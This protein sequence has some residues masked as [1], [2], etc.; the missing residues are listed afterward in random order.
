MTAAPTRMP[1]IY[2]GHGAPPLVD[3]PT[4]PAELAAWARR[5]PRPSAVLVVSAHWESAPLTLS[6]TT[7]CR[8][9]TTSGAS[10]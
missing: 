4:W 8:W 3:D 10:R 1:A 2:L 9:C 5:L 7:R 6:A